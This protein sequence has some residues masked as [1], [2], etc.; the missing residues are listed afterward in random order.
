MMIDKFK[1]DGD[2]ITVDYHGLS[3]S[4]RISTCDEGKKELYQATANVA[5]GARV[6]LGLE[7]LEG[8]GFFAITF[9]RGDEP[10]TRLI[11]SLPTTKTPAKVTCPKLDRG[12]HRDAKTL[13]VVEDHPKT[14][15]E[16][17]VAV[18]EAQIM[19]FVL[20]KRMQMALPFDQSPEERKLTKDVNEF[21]EDEGVTATVETEG[22]RVLDFGANAS[23][24]A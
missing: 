4:F 21:L 9:S 22:G 19:T 18:L 14:W 1:I 17:A 2:M 16:R 7:N 6:L 8:A 10:G 15:Y 12:E 13:Q 3:E 23:A 24:Q 11:L 20:G 5:I